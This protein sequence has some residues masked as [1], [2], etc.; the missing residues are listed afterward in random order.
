MLHFYV[1]SYMEEVNKR[2]LCLAL[3]SFRAAET[4]PHRRLE[5]G[6]VL[7][8][9]R[10]QQRITI[11]FDLFI[12]GFWIDFVHVNVVTKTGIQING[13]VELNCGSKSVEY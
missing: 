2:N 1:L 12:F 7:T 3:L 6:G 11:K 5:F 8:E 9:R 13:L 4:N 10:R